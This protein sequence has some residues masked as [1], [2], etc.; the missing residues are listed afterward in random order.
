MLYYKNIEAA[1]EFYGAT[2]GLKLE[3][4]WEWI[5]FF[6][7][8]PASSVGIVTEGENAWHTAQKTNAAIDFPIPKSP[9][10]HLLAYP[11]L[12]RHRE[13]AR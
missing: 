13:Y 7:T 9:A 3:F 8:G 12:T 6:K 2:R 5:R 10:V 1:S 4:D 11:H